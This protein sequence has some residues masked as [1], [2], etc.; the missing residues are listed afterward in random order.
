MQDST[1][2]MYAHTVR[3]NVFSIVGN[4]LILCD[5]KEKWHTIVKYLLLYVMQNLIIYNVIRF[6]QHR[7]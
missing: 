4:H 2:R 3:S 7:V 6:T 1:V 5:G